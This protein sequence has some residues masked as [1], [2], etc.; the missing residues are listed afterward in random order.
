MMRLTIPWIWRHPLARRQRWQA[1]SRYVRWQIRC[2]VRPRPQQV[3]WVNN[4]RLLLQPGMT[5]ASGNWYVGLHEWPDMAF[6][7][8]LLRP[9][10]TFVDVGSNV[11][12]YSV[13]AAG[14][15]GAGVI[16]VEPSP[17]AAAGLRMNL[18]VNGIQ[19][20]CH[21]VQACLG[22]EPGVLRFSVDRGPMNA[23][24]SA[25]FSGPSRQVAVLRLDDLAGAEQA[26]CWKLDVEG[27]E[28]QV[29]DGAASLLAQ[30]AL[31]VVLLEDRSSA[32]AERML[33]AG[34]RSFSY[35]PWTRLLSSDQASLGGNQIWI[36]DEAWAADRLR[37]APQ[38]RVT[39]IDI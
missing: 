16:A 12:S 13:L 6:V 17:E 18:E 29:L 22:A 23:V 1:Y 7:L 15:I 33:A 25:T 26:C 11:G 32:V 30:P 5:G 28:Q 9:H 34:F 19:D 4:T 3:P 31:K 2:R 10:D 27:F 38:F 14:A 21:I 35:N 37:T 36:R 20:R 39:G 8:H 24:V